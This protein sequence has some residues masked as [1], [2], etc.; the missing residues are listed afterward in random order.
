MSSGTSCDLGYAFISGS[1]IFVSDLAGDAGLNSLVPVHVLVADE[2]LHEV[3]AP[4]ST[5][6][7]ALLAVPVG[8]I[9]RAHTLA[10]HRVEY[11]STPAHQHHAFLL[12]GVV[13][14]LG[15]ALGTRIGRQVVVESSMAADTSLSRHVHE[16]SGIALD[17]PGLIVV[18]VGAH[19]ALAG[20]VVPEVGRYALDAVPIDQVR[21]RGGASAGFE[22][23]VVNLRR[24][25]GRDGI[26]IALVGSVVEVGVL[27]A[28]QARSRGDIVV[29]F[30]R[31]AGA[32]LGGL[33]PV[34][35]KIAGNTDLSIEVGGLDLALASFLSLV[36]DL[37]REL[38]GCVHDALLRIYVIDLAGRAGDASAQ[39]CVEVGS[40]RASQA[41]KHIG[42][43][44]IGQV[45]R[46]ADHT[47]VERS[48]RGTLALFGN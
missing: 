38:A 20:L 12:I 39:G 46:S 8:D 16:G 30:G 25:A 6:G 22:G 10:S 36:V 29:V 17:A 43:P 35:G 27:G 15:G 11:L 19:D 23:L 32:G 47:I 37:S 18:S 45:A 34:V 5:A 48:I 41:L 28:S 40:S 31:T 33:G 26:G 2:A 7:N 13:G 14:K 4:V 21:S 1:I 44:V 42:V 3:G 9:V 24:I